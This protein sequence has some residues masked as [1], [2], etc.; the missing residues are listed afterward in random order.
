MLNNMKKAV[1]ILITFAM[2]SLPVFAGEAVEADYIVIDEDLVCGEG[3]KIIEY[4]GGYAVSFTE[5][6]ID[7]SGRYITGDMLFEFDGYESTTVTITFSG[8]DDTVF[9]FDLPERSHFS[10]CAE[11]SKIEAGSGLHPS[12]IILTSDSEAL[13]TRISC[14]RTPQSAVIPIAAAAVFLSTAFLIPALFYFIRSRR[15][16]RKRFI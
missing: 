16:N 7:V 9:V 10:F 5:A 2:L 1:V 8:A 11:K 13:L 4:N 3:A 15:K 12:Y 14:K 6:K